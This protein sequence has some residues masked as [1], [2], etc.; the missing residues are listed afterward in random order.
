MNS[1]KYYNFSIIGLS[2][3]NIDWPLVKQ[4]DY[5]EERIRERWEARTSVLACSLED[6]PTRCGNQEGVYKL[7]RKEQ[8]KSL[9][10]RGNI[11]QV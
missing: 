10:Q 5:W 11:R 7:S 3:V 8:Q 4:E 1:L 9:S 6:S 2:E